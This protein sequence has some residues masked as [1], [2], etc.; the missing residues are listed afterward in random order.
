M[1]ST[2]HTR[3]LLAGCL[4]R[5]LAILIAATALLLVL[6]PAVAAAGE[7]HDQPTIVL[8][9]GAW[10]GPSS[11]DNVV[12]D[13]H[14]DGYRTVTPRLGLVSLEADVAMVRATLDAVPG[15]KL[16]VAHS[17]GGAVISNAASGRSDVLGLVYAAAFV[18]DQ[19]DSLASLGAGFASS[20][21]VNHFVWTG[22][23][24]A[25]GSL[26]LIDHA[27][28]P[29]FFAQDLPAKQAAALNAAQQPTAFNPLFVTPL[30]PVAW[31]T[32]PSWYAV[33]GADRMIDP[34]EERFMAQRA[35]ATTIELRTA[36]HVGGITLHAGRFTALIEQ[37]VEA[38]TNTQEAGD[39]AE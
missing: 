29:Q 12:R 35:Q 30:G 17:Y 10:A 9:H 5:R 11:W 20:D 24:F 36:S 8:V 23:P 7:R 33:S 14:D 31:H 15:Q 3:R 16:L 6:L 25:P 39:R 27:V 1:T 26:A 32:L 37:A 2:G 21:V 28:F 18:P 34:A 19:G 38:T 13:L 22:A 4:H